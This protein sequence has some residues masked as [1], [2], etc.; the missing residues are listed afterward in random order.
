MRARCG[1]LVRLSAGLWL[2]GIHRN[3]ARSL[4]FDRWWS[5]EAHCTSTSSMMLLGSNLDFLKLCHATPCDML[6]LHSCQRSA[7]RYA[8]AQS[9]AAS[10]TSKSLALPCNQAYRSLFLGIQLWCGNALCTNPT[11]EAVLPKEK[12]AD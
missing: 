12:P 10:S 11:M 5:S 7:K 3:L 8:F 2:C 4:A 6:L 9:C 1:S